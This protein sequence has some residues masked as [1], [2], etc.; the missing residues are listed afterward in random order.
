MKIQSF[1]TD[2]VACG[3][4]AHALTPALRLRILAWEV[5]ARQRNMRGYVTRSVSQRAHEWAGE[6][7]GGFQPWLP[8]RLRVRSEVLTGWGD[9]VM[10]FFR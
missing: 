9:K 10:W 7:A 1:L 2:P 4:S 8:V 3:G 5:V 6:W